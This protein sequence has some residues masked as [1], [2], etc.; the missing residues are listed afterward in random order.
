MTQEELTRLEHFEA[1]F[2][3]LMERFQ[4]L[5]QENAR[6]RDTVA[7]QKQ[8]IQDLQ[9]QCQTAQQQYQD[10][11]LA[12]LITVTD[13]D[14]DTAKRRMAALVREVDKCLALLNT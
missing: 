4:E 5:R 11:K 2:R 9:A 7:T 10:L 14:I 1:H 12:R 13:T 6:L 3:T 8:T